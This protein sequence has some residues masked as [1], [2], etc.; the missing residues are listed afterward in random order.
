MPP[1][2]GFKTTKLIVEFSSGFK[3]L[4]YSWK[5]IDGWKPKRHFV[6]KVKWLFM[7]RK[8]FFFQ[9]IKSLFCILGDLSNFLGSFTIVVKKNVNIRPFWH[10]FLT[11]KGLCNFNTY[12][13]ICKVLENYL[14]F[15]KLCASQ[16]RFDFQP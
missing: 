12:M 4:K 3:L 6:L 10:R 2:S 7:F 14:D 15:C 16:I 11:K 9:Q 8:F 1:S 5:N 13:S